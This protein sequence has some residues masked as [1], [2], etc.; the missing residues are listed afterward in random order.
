[1]AALQASEAAFWSPYTAQIHA[2]E[3]RLHPFSDSF[4]MEFSEVHMQNRAHGV[5]RRGIDA[6][7]LHGD[8]RGRPAIDE[9]GRF[10]GSHVDA[11]VEPAPAP[12]GVAATQE[13]NV[14]AS[15][16]GLF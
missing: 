11:G 13:P 5:D 14:H 4:N 8:E 15:H 1:M 6:E 2:R 7:P 16:N 3:R 9:E 10:L 12:E